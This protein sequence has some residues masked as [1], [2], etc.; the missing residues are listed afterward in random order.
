MIAGDDVPEAEIIRQ[1][2]QVEALRS[3][4]SKTRSLMLYHI[5]RVLTPEQRLKLKAMQEKER[6]RDVRRRSPERR[7]D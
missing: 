4:L 3:E 1:I 6:E 2:D 5:R 7:Q